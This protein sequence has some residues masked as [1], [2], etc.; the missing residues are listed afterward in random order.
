VR[1]PLTA[2]GTGLRV[3]TGGDDMIRAWTGLVL[4]AA[5]T[6][7]AGCGGN[8]ASSSAPPPGTVDPLL[9]DRRAAAKQTAEHD[10]ECTAIQPFYWEIGDG[11][12]VLG[13]GAIPARDG[14]LTYTAT[15]PMSI[16]S[17]SKWLY[18]AYYVQ[19]TQGK[20]TAEDLKFLHFQSGYTSFLSCLNLPGQTVA[21][22]DN[23]GH[24]GDYHAEDDGKFYYSGGHMQQHAVR[25]G[26]GDMNSAQLAT[27]LR[28]QLGADFDFRYVQPQLAGGGQTSA[29]DYG[30]ILRKMLRGELLIGDRLGESSVCASETACPAKVQNSPAPG[31]ES[32]RYSTGHW[33]EDPD[34]VSD[35]AFSSPGLFGFYPWIDKTR[36][37]YGVVARDDLLGAIDS[38]YCGRLIRK[39]WVDAKAP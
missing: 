24:N 25:R 9:A 6:L 20:L 30:N 10:P 15:T 14:T 32:W 26:L 21:E 3:W 29:A 18:A 7:L 38:I 27:E 28:S 11:S 4:L 8:A 39:A 22:C 23:L 16:A 35:G 36:T 34:T 31:G 17:A 19:R 2:R 37:W 1:C 12:G 13:S 5:A 33:V